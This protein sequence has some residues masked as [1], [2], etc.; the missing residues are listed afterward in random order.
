MVDGERSKGFNG[1][2]LYAA[3]EQLLNE[4]LTPLVDLYALGCVLFQMLTGRHPFVDAQT[5]MELIQCASR[6][7]PAPRE[8]LRAGPAA[9]RRSIAAALAKR[10]EARPRDAH[11]QCSA[12]CRSSSALRSRACP[13]SGT[14][15]IENLVSAIENHTSAG[16]ERYATSVGVT[17][18]PMARG[19]HEGVDELLDGLGG[20]PPAGPEA[21]RAIVRLAHEARREA[22]V[23]GAP[24]AA[25]VSVPPA[26]PPV[27]GT[28]PISTRSATTAD[29]AVTCPVDSAPTV[30]ASA[31]RAH[32][33]P[34]LA[35]VAV[36]AVIF[37][38]VLL[39]LGPGRPFGRPLVT[40]S[41]SP[42]PLAPASLV[43]PSAPGAVSSIG[44]DAAGTVLTPAVSAVASTSPPP[45]AST[46]TTPGARPAVAPL[47][48][49]TPSGSPRPPAPTSR[50]AAPAAAPSRR[51][52]PDPPPKDDIN[53]TID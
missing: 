1:T 6:A 5:E 51:P 26:V 19:P 28:P 12:R 11:T 53:R 14:P 46:P 42:P 15:T 4:P 48:P 2:L 39:L 25:S 22:A 43:V 30:E 8:R 34:I 20:R 24:P 47:E 29:P 45:A 18:A 21:A 31:W 35:A 50:P 10:P 23:R 37:A 16:Y 36:G 52:P 17:L 44:A 49:R 9:R 41:A 33:P 38:I 27:T 3:P 40:T 32:G 7:G 13:R